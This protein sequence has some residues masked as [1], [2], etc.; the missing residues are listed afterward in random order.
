MLART[1]VDATVVVVLARKEEQRCQLSDLYTAHRGSFRANWRAQRLS[2]CNNSKQCP[3]SMAIAQQ[4]RVSKAITSN[5]KSKKEKILEEPTS[6]NGIQ[7][8]L[9]SAF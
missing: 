8:L 7:L 1:R 2:E 3:A 9:R 5:T 6:P 4:G